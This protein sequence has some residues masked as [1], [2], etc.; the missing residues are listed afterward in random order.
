MIDEQT[1]ETQTTETGCG[2]GSRGDSANRTLNQVAPTALRLYAEHPGYPFYDSGFQS[3]TGRRKMFAAYDGGAECVGYGTTGWP[4]N[5][6]D[7]RPAS[8]YPYPES[9]QP[10]YQKRF[11][12]LQNLP[13]V[14][15]SRVDEN[16][17]VF[18]NPDKANYDLFGRD[19]FVGGPFLP[20]KALTSPIS[21][22]IPQ[23]MDY[24]VVRD[25]TGP[26]VFVSGVC[27]GKAQ[28]DA[29]VGNVGA[30]MVSR[31]FADGAFSATFRL[32]CFKGRLMRLLPNTSFAF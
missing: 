17:W 25:R 7:V 24:D 11:Q 22:Q 1:E 14:M 16:G 8:P 4:D 27:T 31:P 5:G 21:I 23:Q 2:A 6:Y 10:S 28:E 13:P 20:S 26:D 30:E 15:T 12:V 3:K 19:P 9:V 32:K 18:P 29:V